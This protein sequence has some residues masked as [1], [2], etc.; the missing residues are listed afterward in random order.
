MLAHVEER[1]LVEYLGEAVGNLVARADEVRL[2]RTVELALAEAALPAL[3]VLSFLRCASVV[4]LFNSCRIVHKKHGGATAE[5]GADGVEEMAEKVVEE[6]VPL[7]S[8]TT[9][10]IP[11]AVSAWQELAA[12]LRRRELQSTG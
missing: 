9:G 12:T 7:G 2:G 6:G 11:A 3:V 10:C 5:L 4:S 8:N 1:G